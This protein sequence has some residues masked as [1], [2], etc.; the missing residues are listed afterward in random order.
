PVKDLIGERVADLVLPN[1]DDMSYTKIRLDKRSIATQTE[2]VADLADP[3]ARAL[4]WTA[5]IDQLRDA[6]LAARDYV[7]LVVNNIHTETDP[8]AA[9]QLLGGAAQ[10]ITLYGDPK[11][12][13]AARLQL[14]T[15]ALESAKAA[16]GGSDLQLLW[17]RALISN[18]RIDEHVAIVR[19]LLD[20]TTSFEGLTVDTD[21]RWL[22]VHALAGLGV[23][24]GEV[25][26][27]RLERDPTDQG[28]RYAAGARAA[29]PTSEA[30]AEA[31][32]RIVDHSDTP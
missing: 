31:W 29:R 25:I 4:C 16:E 30:K 28:Q 26:G 7:R 15:R 9:Q 11:N 3:L 12:R 32:S 2:H 22:I 17:A 21:L 24:D 6:E 27:P 19:G 13:D 1:D 14:A 18:S 23:I 8:G 10:A 5:A 20:G